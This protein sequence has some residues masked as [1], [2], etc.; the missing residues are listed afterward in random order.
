MSDRPPRPAGPARL[1]LF[2]GLLLAL[3][4]L[5][6]EGVAFLTG[7]LVPD[8]YDH[9]AAVLSRIGPEVTAR[10]AR[11]DPVLGWEPQPGTIRRAGDCRGREV[12]YTVAADGA[13]DYPGYRPAAATIL[14]GGDSY[15]F[16]D[17]AQDARA[18][19]AILAGLTGKTVANLGV[20]GYGP[21][22]ALLRLERH[23]E[24]YPAARTVVLGIMYENVHRMV[25]SYRPVLYDQADPLAFLPHMRDGRLRPHP[26][27]QALADEAR[28]RASI[29]AAFDDDFWAKPRRGFPYLVSMIEGLSSRYFILRTVQRK[30]SRTGRARRPEY[31]MSYA[32]PEI[33]ANLI[34]LLDRFANLAAGRGLEAVALF[35][36]RN[37]FDTTSVQD[38]LAATGERFPP[39]V[40]VVDLG[41]GDVD[42]A[43]YNLVNPA[44]GNT[45]H[46]S[47]YGYGEIA[48][49]LA[50]ALRRDG[51]RSGT[52]R[53]RPGT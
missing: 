1:V 29:E 32:S 40:A 42:W 24:R 53:A 44:D 17:E 30:L 18:F 5:V 51:V 14:V 47:S 39:G 21:V 31:G 28:L 15:A 52:A 49:H 37:R 41:A 4:V 8:L 11:V 48:R 2:W 34:G 50:G 20:R 45:C 35:M 26:G 6:L 12:S 16:G 43:R 33:Q 46:P 3:L 27:R 19:P 25:N 38:L 23:V 9:R 10:A 36:P 22:Q 7:L 13:R